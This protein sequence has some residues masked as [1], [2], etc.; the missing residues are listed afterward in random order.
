M[1][2][3]LH[4]W[5][6]YTRASSALLL[7]IIN[8]AT[9]AR[10]VDTHAPLQLSDLN[11]RSYSLAQFYGKVVI[12]N[13]WASWCLPCIQELPDLQ[14]LKQAFA[15]QPFEVITVNTGEKKYRVRKFVKLI[16]LDL[17]VWLDTKKKAFHDWEV[18][19]LP[20]SF[21]LDP[22][23]KVQYRI[24]GNPGWLSQATRGSLQ[25]LMPHAGQ[26]TR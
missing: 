15:G 26:P 6:N 5:V 25:A 19:T 1:P 7:L 21:V 22:Q 12:V 9:S 11:D 13:F 3:I 16:G 17:P 24:Q 2:R 8:F 23:G 14:R 4:R 18:E 20:T 10:S